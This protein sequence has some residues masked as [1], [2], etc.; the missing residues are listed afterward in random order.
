MGRS[1]VIALYLLA[2]FV[3]FVTIKG[4]LNQYLAVDGISFAP[5]KA[6]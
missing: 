1:S 2:A 5:A 3:I 4:Q 6:A